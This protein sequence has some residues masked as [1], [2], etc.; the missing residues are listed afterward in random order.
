MASR[1]ARVGRFAEESNP[2]QPEPTAPNP[3][4]MKTEKEMS[5]E[6]CGRKLVPARAFSDGSAELSL[7]LD[8]YQPAKHHPC[9]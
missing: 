7:P 2:E 9:T 3:K 1:I 5:C 8:K 6:E 4:M